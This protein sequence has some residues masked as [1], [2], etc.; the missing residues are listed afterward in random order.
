MSWHK[1]TNN[2]GQVQTYLKRF[3]THFMVVTTYGD[4]EAA[5]ILIESTSGARLDSKDN[6]G[7][8]P[9]DHARTR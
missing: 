9:L 4:E 3:I 6:N 8:T 1:L 5:K 2:L 7:K